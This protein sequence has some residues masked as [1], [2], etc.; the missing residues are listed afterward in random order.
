MD[1]EAK[2]NDARAPTYYGQHLFDY[3]SPEE[4]K[5]YTKKKTEGL[6]FRQFN[7]WPHPYNQLY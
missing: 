4:H 7:N 3:V 5:S 6:A 1:A 2:L